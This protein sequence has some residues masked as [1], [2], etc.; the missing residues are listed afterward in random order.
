MCL[1]YY[2][3]FRAFTVVSIFYDDISLKK[4]SK[5]NRPMH[6]Q[7]HTHWHTF[8]YTRTLN[9]GT[10][11]THKIWNILIGWP[12]RTFGVTI[13]NSVFRN[14]T[15]NTHTHT[16]VMGSN[17]KNGFACNFAMNHVPGSHLFAQR[18]L[19]NR[20]YISILGTA[21]ATINKSISVAFR[22]PIAC[23]F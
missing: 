23:R 8:A 3:L 18:L 12:F 19:S 10:M 15:N 5:S 11:C 22:I 21:A 2:Y 14:D 1:V 17:G 7:T 9:V 13:G 20:F 6:R 16:H 4:F